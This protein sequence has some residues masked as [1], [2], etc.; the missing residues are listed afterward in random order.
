M[1]DIGGKAVGNVDAARGDLHQ[2][3]SERRARPGPVV[4]VAQKR[5]AVAAGERSPVAG[6]QKAEGS[7]ADRAG[8]VKIIADL[9]P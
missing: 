5:V 6:H 9:R 2:A 4:T 1:A 8:Q 3:R 7:V